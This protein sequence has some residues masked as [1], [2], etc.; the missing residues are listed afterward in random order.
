MGPGIG[1]W[2]GELLRGHCVLTAIVVLFDAICGEN[3]SDYSKK[4]L[5]Q[6]LILSIKQVEESLPAVLQ[7]KGFCI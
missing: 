6:H 5:E 7:P 1:Q 4:E 2:D 3:S